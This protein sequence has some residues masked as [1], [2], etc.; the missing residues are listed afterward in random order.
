MKHKS[1][2]GRPREFD[3]DEAL[4]AATA[5]FWQHSYSGSQVDKVVAAMGMSKPSVYA[6]FG[7]KIDIYISELDTFCDGLLTA[8]RDIAEEDGAL[9]PK[10]IKFFQREIEFYCQENPPRGC[11]LFC[12]APAETSNDPRIRQKLAEMIQKIDSSFAQIIRHAIVSGELPADA[13]EV[14]VAR[15]LQSLLQAVAIRSRA[16]ESAKSLRDSISAQLK[17]MF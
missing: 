11:F 9:R 5:V 10:L 3:P 13:D 7:S 4:N 16:G 6:A 17:Y 8:I 2:G 12:T 14:T 15:N 1:K